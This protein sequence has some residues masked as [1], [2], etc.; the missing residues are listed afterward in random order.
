MTDLNPTETPLSQVTP[1]T[2]YSSTAHIYSGNQYAFAGEGGYTTEQGLDTIHRGTQTIIEQFDI[3]GA[4][5]VLFDVRIFNDII[6]IQKD[7]SNINVLTTGFYDSSTNMMILDEVEVTAVQFLAGLNSTVSN[8]VSIGKY[9][10]LYSD[11][12]SYVAV[13]F[14]LS[15]ESPYTS[16]GFSTLF[17]GEY[18]FSPYNNGLFDA[19]AFMA[20]I[21]GSG[22]IS[23]GGAFVD[24]LSGSIVISN[25]TQLL[26]NAVDANPFGN[27]DV[28]GAVGYASDTNHRLN[29]GVTDGFFADDLIFIPDAG[30]TITLK[31]AVDTEGYPLPLNNIGPS[32]E[33]ISTVGPVQDASYNSNTTTT[34]LTSTFTQQSIFTQTSTSTV[35]LITRTTKAPLLIRLSNLSHVAIIL[36]IGTVSNTSITIIITS[37]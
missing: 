15:S 27:R 5:E 28:S 35:N 2:I 1:N 22:D 36:S 18:D 31:L 8:I 19:S 17:S 21:S 26:R 6:G 37:V 34:T 23:P 13:Y 24:D 32:N 4:V 16:L 25:I 7:A 30:I 14:G 33:A 20:I 9:D 11:F 3:T 10:T 12:A 29:Y